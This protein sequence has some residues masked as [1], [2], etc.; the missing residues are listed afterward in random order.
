M[1]AAAPLLTNGFVLTILLLQ[2]WFSKEAD[3]QASHMEGVAHLLNASA[4]EE[5]N[6][7]FNS[8]MRLNM[9]YPTVSTY[10]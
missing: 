7:E 6:D 1:A 4:G 10:L 3:G 8:T 5:W 9:I 2:A